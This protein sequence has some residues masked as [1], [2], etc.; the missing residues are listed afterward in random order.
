MV[1]CTAD[2]RP[3]RQEHRLMRRHPK[4]RHRL[5]HQILL[6]R[7]IEISNQRSNAHRLVF[8]QGPRRPH[9]GRAQSRCRHLVRPRSLV[10]ASSYGRSLHEEEAKSHPAKADFRQD[11]RSPLRKTP[12]GRREALGAVPP[13]G[14]SLTFPHPLRGK[15]GVAEPDNTF[16]EQWASSPYA[17][18]A[19]TDLAE[20]A[21]DALNSAIRPEPIS[22]RQLL[23]RGPRRHEFAPA[24]AK[25]RTFCAAGQGS[26]QI[27]S[28]IS[29]RKSAAEITSSP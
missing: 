16:Y 1:T 6:R 3:Q 8:A 20:K 22:S 7:R 17:D 15:T 26:R 29:I 11:W 10:T 21:V 19:L 14:W 27:Y 13:E 24:A 23:L 2:S 25:S 5:A 28:P 9:H 4:A 18:T 12:I